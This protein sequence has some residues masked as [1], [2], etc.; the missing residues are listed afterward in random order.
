MQDPAVTARQTAPVPPRPETTSTITVAARSATLTHGTV[1]ALRPV[2]F[3][4]TAGQCLAVT[5]PNGSGKST[6]LS[7]VAGRSR[8]TSGDLDVLGV[9]AT[10]SRRS[11]ARQVSVLIGAFACYPDLTVHEHLQLIAASWPAPDLHENAEQVLTGAGLRTVR[12][13][14]P[15]ELSS[16]ESQIFAL[17]CA[18]MRPARVLVLDEPEQ[19]LDPTRAT[20]AIAVLA[21]ARARGT[22]IVMAT[23]SSDFRQALADEVL[24]L[25]PRDAA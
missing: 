23:H 10:Q 11:H 5:G 20:Q 22:S 18:T 19:R 14:L 4:L 6:L 7:L 25:Q 8:P 15:E 2:T 3:T 16:G 24:T 17:A 9:P 21:R 1:Q 12:D 13:Q